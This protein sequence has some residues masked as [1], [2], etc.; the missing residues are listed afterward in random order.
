MNIEIALDPYKIHR[1]SSS[2][3][4]Q[5][6]DDYIKARYYIRELSEKNTPIKLIVKNRGLIGWFKDLERMA[7]FK[8]IFPAETLKSLLTR[9]DL[10]NILIQYP[11]KIVDLNLIELANNN[12]IKPN[13]SSLDWI[14]EVTISF[15]WI[16]ENLKESGDMLQVLEW[17]LKKRNTSID[18]VLVQLCIEKIKVWKMVSP[19]KELLEW[20]EVD[21]FERGYLF[22]VCQVI[23]A[24]PESEKARWLQSDGQWSTICQLPNHKKW[25]NDIPRTSKIEINPSLGIRIKDYIQKHLD[26]QGL[27]IGIVKELSGLLKVEEDVIYRYLVSPNV[28]KA[29]LPTDVI[30]VMQGK[31]AS[32][33]IRDFLL[34]LRLVDPPPI[35]ADNSPFEDVVIWLD[36][37]Y[38]PYRSWCRTVDREELLDAPVENF[39]KW[40]VN[41]YRDLLST[42]PDAFVCN[43]RKTVH[44]LIENGACVLLVI[45][46]GLSWNWR[47]HIIRKIKDIGLYLERDPEIR[48]SMLPSISEVSKPSIISGLDLFDEIRSPSLSLEYYNQLFK[49][50]YKKYAG[51]QVVA[52]DSTDTLFS[53]L[54]E[55]SN[56]YLYLF[57]EVDSIAHEYSNDVLRD[58]NIRIALDKLLLNL[59]SAVQE[60]ERLHQSRLKIVL[61]G[62]HGYL[63]LPR[64]FNEP[65][66][67]A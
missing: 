41:K 37:Y 20:L 31:F 3:A 67:W 36:K 27:T 1:E 59:V 60:Y 22:S 33:E 13:Q 44:S 21:P 12:P 18:N 15:P 7:S 57:N 51:V 55:E 26:S 58:N 40:F 5:T 2:F 17:I 61:I 56:V 8:T 29:E 25:L 23:E 42:K 63:T 52:T 38:F 9:S 54:R 32:G 48:L 19:F 66:P 10:P 43:T 62:D 65:T 14:L 28:N 64:H 39:E 6:G 49:E 47:D 11:Q 45:V 34:K 24:Y 4:I 16:R 35:I 30:D 46:D 53:L 50:S